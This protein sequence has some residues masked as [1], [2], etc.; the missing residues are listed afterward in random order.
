MFKYIWVVTLFILLQFSIEDL[1]KLE[2]KG[3]CLHNSSKYVNN[4]FTIVWLSITPT[5]YKQIAYKYEL[6]LLS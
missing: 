3:C 4:I 2:L 6:L 5:D 1:G